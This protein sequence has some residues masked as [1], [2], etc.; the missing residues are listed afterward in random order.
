MAMTLKQFRSKGGKARQAQLSKE[1]RRKLMKRAA[2][3][4]WGKSKSR[5]PQ[6]PKG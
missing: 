1:Q 4:R 6:T 2:A 5:K 3:A